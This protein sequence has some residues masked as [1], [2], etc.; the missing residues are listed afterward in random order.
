MS[1]T[2]T[3]VDTITSGGS[4]ADIAFIFDDTGSMLE[5]IA[6]MQAGATQFATDVINAGI[7]SRFALVSFKDDQ[8]IDLPFT[9]D[10]ATFQT[11]VN[12]LV[13]T[14]GDDEPE[15]DLDACMLALNGLTYRSGRFGPWFPSG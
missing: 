2:I 1:Q 8:E 14:G 7:D 3:S 6:A 10:V 9:S 13:A 4:Q 11:A 5:E 12:N 15:N